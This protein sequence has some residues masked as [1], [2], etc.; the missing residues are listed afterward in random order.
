MCDFML[1]L[2]RFNCFVIVLTSFPVALVSAAKHCPILFVLKMASTLVNKMH[3]QE[4]IYILGTNGI[5]L[6]TEA[7]FNIV[8]Q[9]KN[10]AMFYCWIQSHNAKKKTTTTTLQLSNLKKSRRPGFCKV[11][12]NV[13]WPGTQTFDPE[14]CQICEGTSLSDCQFYGFSIYNLI[15]Q[16]VV[17]ALINYA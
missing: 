9:S 6:S 5:F 13:N 3:C 11:T 16:D 15:Y 4:I 1:F 17:V 7:K 14:A 8:R 10:Q 2:L 12:D